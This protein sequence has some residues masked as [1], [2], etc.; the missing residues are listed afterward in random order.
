MNLLC[1]DH[2][3]VNVGLDHR[4]D[5]IAEHMVHAMVRGTDVPQPKGHGSIAIHTIRGDKRSH[6]LV[7]LFHPDLV[8]TGI[9]I[10]E[11]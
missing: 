9:G 6:E 10:K 7:K 3:V 5:V 8:I 1:L 4:T 11:G 2:D